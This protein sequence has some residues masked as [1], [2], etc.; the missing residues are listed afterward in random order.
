MTRTSATQ[1]AD[2]TR[3]TADGSA[4]PT[5]RQVSRGDPPT[6]PVHTTRS[7]RLEPRSLDE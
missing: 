5:R 1:S 4:A 7:T 2:D 3:I 6:S